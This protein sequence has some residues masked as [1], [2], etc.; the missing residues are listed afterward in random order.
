[1]RFCPDL[2]TSYAQIFGKMCLDLV[3]DIFQTNYYQNPE[4]DLGDG[5][6]MPVPRSNQSNGRSQSIRQEDL[7]LLPVTLACISHSLVCTHS[8]STFEYHATCIYPLPNDQK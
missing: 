3:N 4:T 5:R 1:M 2:R 8:S 6:M 7:P